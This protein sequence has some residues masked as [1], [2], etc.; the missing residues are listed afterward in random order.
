V[1][2]KA[3]AALGGD[4][5]AR[6]DITNVRSGKLVALKFSHNDPHR[7]AVWLCHCDCGRD[8]YVLASYIS[9]NIVKSCGCLKLKK[10]EICGELMAGNGK[11]CST[12][13][14][15]IAHIE[16]TKASQKRAAQQK[17]KKKKKLAPL[18]A[19]LEELAEYNRKHG[20]NLSYGQY[21]HLKEIEKRA[22]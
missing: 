11:Y 22:V 6:L 21:V 8:C 12:E 10:C 15:R 16:R 7:R 18:D 1:A 13:C 19:I 20:T 4:F 3:L 2:V 5:M 14:R 17:K 9:R